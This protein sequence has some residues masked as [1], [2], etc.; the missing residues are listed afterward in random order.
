MEQQYIQIAISFRSAFRLAK[1]FNGLKF[2]RLEDGSVTSLTDMR[3]RI[4][5]LKSCGFK[6]ER[7]FDSMDSNYIMIKKQKPIKR[8][9]DV[10]KKW[11]DHAFDCE[12]ATGDE[13]TCWCDE[14]YHGWKGQ[15]Q[16][17]KKMLITSEIKSEQK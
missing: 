8:W 6:N 3:K 9:D 11:R 4:R 5:H 14:C 13:C 16:E 1:Q 10:L 2:M 17:K 7:I 15:H 12:F